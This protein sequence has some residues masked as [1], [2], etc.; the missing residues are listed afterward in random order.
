MM[1][2]GMAR[3]LGR[4][5]CDAYKCKNYAPEGKS[6]CEACERSRESRK[7][8]AALKMMEDEDYN[9]RLKIARDKATQER[10][11]AKNDQ[12]PPGALKKSVGTDL[13]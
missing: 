12:S 4:V 9:E 6:L 11:I 1:A 5:P 13:R 10:C 7:I 8:K 3:A 2:E